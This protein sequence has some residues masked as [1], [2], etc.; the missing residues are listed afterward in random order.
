MTVRFKN[1]GKR[2]SDATIY[3]YD[4]PKI[5]REKG[6]ERSKRQH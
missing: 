3:S 5:R 2:K 6:R 1:V 4:L